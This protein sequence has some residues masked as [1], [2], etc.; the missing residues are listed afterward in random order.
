VRLLLDTHTAIWWW[1][2]DPKLARSAR[3]LI[4]DRTHDVFVSAATGW[5]IA[6]KVQCGKMPEMTG[7]VERFDVLVTSN[8]FT[9]IA[10]DHIH[11]T[12]AGSTDGR[13]RD[14]FDRL[15]AAQARIED[16]TLV[17]K[18]RHM[19]QFGCRTAW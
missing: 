16:M 13:N 12:T 14:P 18:D 1:L 15:L 19:G 11:A 4:A 7:Q 2:N 5:E 17:T 6:I 3:A 10:I 9:H 8:G